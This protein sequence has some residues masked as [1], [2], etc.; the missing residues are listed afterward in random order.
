MM[1]AR[2]RIYS[3]RCWVWERPKVNR[4]EEES[5]RFHLDSP[6]QRAAQRCVISGQKS[7]SL[8]QLSVMWLLGKGFSI[9]REMMCNCSRDTHSAVEFRGGLLRMAITQEEEVEVE[10]KKL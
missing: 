2:E 4:K 7:L 5:K 1:R 9:V 8:S 3:H 6:A 10:R